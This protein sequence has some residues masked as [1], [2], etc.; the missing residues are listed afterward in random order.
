MS[1]ALN[2]NATEAH[3]LAACK[4]RKLTV[5][6]IEGLTSGGTRLVMNNAAD[7]AMIAAFYGRKVISGVV[8]RT[9]LR[10]ATR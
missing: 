1:R 9:P 6:A 5:S 10:P 7:A 3:V 4:K 2:I 8:T